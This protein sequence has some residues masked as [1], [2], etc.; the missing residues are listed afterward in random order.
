MSKQET[1][2]HREY[3]QIVAAHKKKL[4]ENLKSDMVS[5]EGHC[6]TE[7]GY[8]GEGNVWND[9]EYNGY[10]DCLELFET[11]RGQHHSGHSAYELYDNNKCILMKG[12]TF[13]KGD[14]ARGVKCYTFRE[15]E[16]F[17]LS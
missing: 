11:Y 7:N 2:R 3:E 6:E 4:D 9:G 15:P 8:K 13:I 17:E 5:F 1:D 14:G 10:R 16:K 12:G